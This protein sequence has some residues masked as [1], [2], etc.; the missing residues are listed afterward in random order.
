MLSIDISNTQIRIVEAEYRAG[1]VK[2]ER[3]DMIPTPEGSVKNGIITNIQEL[4]EG[5]G[6][7]I[8]RNKFKSKK[9]AVTISSGAVVL[10]EVTVPWVKEKELYG[11][12]RNE[13]EQMASA[14]Q[15]YILDYVVLERVREQENDMC[16]ALCIM[17][18]RVIVESYRD[19]IER[20][21]GLQ[22]QVFDV[23][24]HVLYKLACLDKRMEATGAVILADIA[25][26]EVRLNLVEGSSRIFNLT[27]PVSMVKDVVESEY[28]LSA[29][30][31]DDMMSD[32][33]RQTHIASVSAENISKLIQF[34]TMKNKDNP[35]RAVLACGELSDDQALVSMMTDHLGREVSIITPPA[36][37]QCPD[38]LVFSQYI[39]AISAVIAL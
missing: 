25:S 37:I 27:A 14:K 6:A 24:P 34:Q 11:L 5:L 18:P 22:A 15:D 21:L 10:R 38:G 16:R 29:I 17:V 19:L 1:S 2:I 13:M 36:F 26:D 30:G 28:I 12:L 23:Q 20:H 7:C 32:Q 4:A 39:N 3:F 9:T 31:T 8:K 33:A 35:V